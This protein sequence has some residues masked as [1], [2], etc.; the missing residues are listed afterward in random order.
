MGALTDTEYAAAGRA[1]LRLVVTPGPLDTPCWIFAG[2]TNVVTGY[3]QIRQGRR[4]VSVHRLL[5]RVLV[6]VPPD[7]HDI[8]HRCEA[9]ACANPE[10]LDCKPHVEHIMGHGSPAAVNARKTHC[11]RQHEFTEAN[12][13]RMPD[14]RRQCRTCGREAF[15]RRYVPVALRDAA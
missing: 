8:H 7:G 4:V 5:Y 13:Y 1:L 14:G 9:P 3:G 12:T 10:H 6:G 15:R 2:S 11:I